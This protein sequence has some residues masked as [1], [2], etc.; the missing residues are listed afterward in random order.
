MLCPSFDLMKHADR[1]RLLGREPIRES[2]AFGW[3]SLYFERIEADE[4]ETM[5]HTLTDHYMM[6]KVSPL[7]HAE[8]RLDGRTCLERQIR[9]SSVYIPKGCPH[10][11]RYTSPLGQLY[12]MVISSDLIK[13][14][15]IEM[16]VTSLPEKPI[17]T[18]QN[19]FL[20]E[21][22]LSI[23]Q[24]LQARNPHG[25]VF[26]EIYGRLL[27]SKIIATVGNSNID[28]TSRRIA[29]TTRQL[30]WLDDFIDANLAHK[31]TLEDMAGQVALSP[32][33]F[34]RVFKE[35]TGI[36]PHAYLTGRRIDCA[37]KGLQSDHASILDVALS[38]GFSDASHFSR[39][40]N[41]H[42]G[43]SP[44]EYRREVNCSTSRAIS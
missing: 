8:R 34:C 3:K 11:V 23:D 24:E 20:L 6:V 10:Q 21:V 26:S 5:E 44:S 37:K 30:R 40:F 14:V 41:K 17:F 38:A 19:N 39:V 35:A 28:N 36:T 42:T 29:L 1:K 7:S 27:A 4:F 33:H 18:K 15:A 13:S 12:L 32:F 43:V 2:S 25:P 16:G 9:G 22:A 31:I